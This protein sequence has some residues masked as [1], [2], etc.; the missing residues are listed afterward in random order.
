MA[1]P[2]RLP[3]FT[4]QSLLN[5][6]QVELATPADLPRLQSLLRRHHYL[7]GIRPVGERLYYIAQ[8]ASAD[9]L[10][11]LVFSAPA[12]HLKDRERWIGWTEEQRRRRLS[13]VTNNSRFLILPERSVPNLGSRVLSLTLG[14]LSADWQNR[15]G[16]P[17]E[18]VET[19]V[20]PEQ[21]CGTVYT[22]SGWTELGQTDGWGRMRRDYYVKHDKPKRLFVRALRPRSCRSLQAEHLKPDLAVVEARVPPR[23]TRRAREIRS[24]VEH[25]KKLPEYRER[26]ESYPLFSLAALILLAM[27]CEAPRGQTDL[28]KFAGGLNQGQRRALGIR[29]NPDGKYPAP[30]QSTFSRFFAGI[31]P[32]KLEQTL[33]E[34]QT[35]LRGPAPR[36]ELVVIDG[37]EPR[38]GSG[39]SV[40]SAVTVP[41]QH[42]LGS[43]LVDQKT[44]E[45]PV[46]QKELI[47]ALDLEGR[48]VSL[49]AL[50]TQDE[51]A[52]AVVLEGGG[53]YFLT[54]KNNQATL[55]A[56]LEN[57]VTAPRADFPPGPTH[58]DP[59]AD[60]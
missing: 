45:I 38:H 53:D 27:L 16:H 8:D 33:L 57:K 23:C 30:S 29:R 1:K 42:F 7:G 50:H 15:Y 59:G 21:F 44:N 3:D 47:P 43:A 60:L 11:V 2:K 24:V 36:N 9:W 54:A 5:E 55:R 22:A 28:A 31:D 6:V 20:D 4:Q 13:L 34:I 39:T 40:L 12:K 49:D 37:K 18:I 19:F 25:F 14:R 51:T 35:L 32:R 41:S 10:A 26:V 46:A 48:L 56:N 52:R 58:L 17:V